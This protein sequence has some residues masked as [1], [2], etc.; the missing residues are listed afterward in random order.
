MKNHGQAGKNLFKLNCSQKQANK[1]KVN[2][3]TKFGNLI[4]QRERKSNSITRQVKRYCM[5]NL[6][7][8]KKATSRQINRLIGHRRAD[9]Q[10][11]R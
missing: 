11:N 3:E 10:A 6:F 2:I 7:L 9:R 1:H 5:P 8:F 4:R